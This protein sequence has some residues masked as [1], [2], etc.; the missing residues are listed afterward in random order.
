M[1]KA[2]EAAVENAVVPLIE[3]FRIVQ[4]YQTIRGNWHVF[5]PKSAPYLNNLNL[6]SALT[7][8]RAI[9]SGGAI[10]LWTTCH[11]AMGIFAHCMMGYGPYCGRILARA[12]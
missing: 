12:S 9:K 1:I 11:S 3:F 6:G 8:S 4:P 2:E 10:A 5:E 7:P